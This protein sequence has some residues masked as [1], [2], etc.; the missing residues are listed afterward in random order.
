MRQSLDPMHLDDR[1]DDLVGS[2]AG[3]HGTW[4]VY[5]GVELGLFARLRAARPDGLTT[6]ELAAATGCQPV[7]IDAWAWAADAHELAT[8]DGDR[9]TV[10]DDIAVVL[11]DEQRPEYLGGQFVHS[12]VAS[13]DWGGDARL[14]PDRAP[15]ADRARTATASRSSG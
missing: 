9:L 11:L 14:L 6:A 15:I 7:A 1:F 12:V 13:L 4:L 8:L 3:F 10:D 5:L 2:L